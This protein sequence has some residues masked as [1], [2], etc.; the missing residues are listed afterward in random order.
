VFQFAIEGD[1]DR[2]RRIR[3]YFNHIEVS[4]CVQQLD[5]ASDALEQARR[6]IGR[7][8]SRK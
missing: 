1:D 3:E 5:A 6:A 2:I 4:A 7:S 8:Q